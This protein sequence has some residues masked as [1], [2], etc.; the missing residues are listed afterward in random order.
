MCWDVL[1]CPS[2][3]VTGLKNS[4]PL[5]SDLNKLTTLGL[6]RSCSALVW[7]T[8][9]SE[10]EG[11]HMAQTNCQW[12]NR[13]A[14]TARGKVKLKWLHFSSTIPNYR[15]NLDSVILSTVHSGLCR[16]IDSKD[17]SLQSL[18]LKTFCTICLVICKQ[19]E[20]VHAT[21]SFPPVGSTVLSWCSSF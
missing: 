5:Q 8:A 11:R 1:H 6:L 17:A 20:W 13:L 10:W 9:C 15:L 19:D 18:C 7:V 21:A 16:H 12:E 2:V 4:A 14:A 3:R